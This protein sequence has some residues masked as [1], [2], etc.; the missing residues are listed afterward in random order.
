[1]SFRVGRRPVPGEAR[2]R[3]ARRKLDSSVT[4]LSRADETYS[5]I[6]RFQYGQSWPP[7]G[8]QSSTEWRMPRDHR[9]PESWYVGRE[10]S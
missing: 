9:T 4:A 10:S 3:T 8:P 6:W 7:S 1:M 5:F 2:A